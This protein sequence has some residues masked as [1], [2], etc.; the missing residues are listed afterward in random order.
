MEEI[1]EQIS[2]ELR[3]AMDTGEPESEID[4]LVAEI[5]MNLEQAEKELG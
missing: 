4:A 5:K 1:E 2:T 3:Q